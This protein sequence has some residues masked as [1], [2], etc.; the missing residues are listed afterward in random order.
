MNDLVVA[1]KIGQRQKLKALTRA[2]NCGY[3]TKKSSFAIFVSPTD[4]PGSVS[5]E[6]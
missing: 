1:E 3:R 6:G 5:L 4:T 2:K